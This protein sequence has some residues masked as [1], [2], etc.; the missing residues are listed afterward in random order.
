MTE[1]VASGGAQP[2][3][4]ADNG[5]GEKRHAGT[6][7]RFL[8][9]KDVS[10]AYRDSNGR[11][12][13]DVLDRFSLHIDRGETAALVGPN[14]SGK[15]TLMRIINGL[16]FPDSGEYL[17]DG[18]PVTRTSMADQGFAK[19]LHQRI[20]FVFQNS[21]TQLF[22]TSVREEI[23]FGPLQMG[24]PRDEVQRRVDDMVTL[25]HLGELEENAPY[26]LSGGQRKRV[27]VACCLS[28]NPDLL[29]L[30]EPTDGL[31]EGNTW[32]VVRVLRSFAASGKSILISTHHPAIVEALEARRIAVF[33]LPQGEGR[34]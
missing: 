34:P 32:L 26:T 20:G 30:D 1:A 19:S 17:F 21:D 10:F 33:P 16:E 2:P 7:D 8:A 25:F 11:P 4:R 31:D 28:L 15:T 27:A 14:G 6:N 13:H 9:L 12:V 5:I 29:V 24:L 23:A 3:V 18:S 22:C